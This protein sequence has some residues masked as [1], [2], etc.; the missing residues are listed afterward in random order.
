MR[1]DIPT[2]APPPPPTRDEVR[3]ALAIIADPVR[4]IG[5][6][7]FWF[8]G[9]DDLSCGCPAEMHTEHD[10]VVVAHTSVLELEMTEAHEEGAKD[11][12][13]TQWLLA[14]QLWR[15]L[16]RRPELWRHVRHRIRALG[17]PRLND[18]TTD[19]M[20]ADLPRVL[21]APLIELAS[22]S[23]DPSRL[24]EHARAWGIGERAVAAERDRRAAEVAL[25]MEVAVPRMAE[26]LDTMTDPAEFADRCGAF[27]VD[28]T[29]HA[30]LAPGS[31]ATAPARNQVA[32]LIS[33]YAMRRADLVHLPRETVEELFK[34]SLRVAADHATRAA[35]ERGHQAFRAEMRRNHSLFARRRRAP[36]RGR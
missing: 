30:A 2:W 32:M 8:W 26:T 36:G 7:L 28:A 18:D 14:G 20:R 17:D 31:T 15:A 23:D 24:I 9:E 27:M 35:L 25:R 3:E 33:R 13:D 22:V 1:Y 11:V 6:E 4:R 16:L 19:R 12:F 34:L 21:V 5:H 29:R 10:M